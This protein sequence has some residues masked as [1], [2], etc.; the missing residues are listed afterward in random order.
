MPSSLAAE[1]GQQRAATEARTGGPLP[2]GFRVHAGNCAAP[3]T[4]VLPAQAGAHGAFVAGALAG[5]P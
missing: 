4:E 2:T 1:F 3:A 5:L